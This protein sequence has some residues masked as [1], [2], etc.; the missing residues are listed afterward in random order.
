MKISRNAPA[1][2]RPLEGKKV[3]VAG[4]SLGLDMQP[5]SQ[6]GAFTCGLDNNQY[7]GVPNFVQ[8][9]ATCLPFG[10]GSF[11]IVFSQRLVDQLIP[12]DTVQFLQEA[13][14]V[15]KPGGAM[16]ITHLLPEQ[17][18]N[19]LIDQG[20]KLGFELFESYPL[21]FSLKKL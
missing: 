21:A 13:Y 9:D 17:E 19:Y 12:A 8:A 18:R 14:R 3:L 16:I 10:N 15:L 2:P 1:T 5:F 11:D 6:A 20:R 7:S 4:C